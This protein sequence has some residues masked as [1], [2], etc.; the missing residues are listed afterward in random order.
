[1][2]LKD[3]PG[4]A[5][6]MLAALALP[7]LAAPD[8]AAQTIPDSASLSVDYL[9]YR[10]KQPGLDRVGV[11]SPSVHL[12]LPLAGQW[13]LEAGAVSDHVSGATPRYHTAVSGASRMD[14]K[15]NAADL[16]VTRYLGKASVSAGAAHSSE[17]D[18]RSTALSLGGTLSTEDRNTTGGLA[19][20]VSNDTI[21]PVNLLVVG[22]RRHTFEW[23]ASVEQVLGQRDIVKLDFSRSDGHGYYADPYKYADKRPRL[24]KLNS[25]LLRWNHALD[26]GGALRT[27]YRYY[28]DSFGIRS[29]TLGG[30]YER[31]LGGG[32]ALTPALRLYTQSS[33][34]FY[35]DPV[36]DPRFG[37]PFPP[38]YT[39][40][41]TAQLS[42]DQRLSAF[43]AATLGLKLARDVGAG[44]SVHLK[45]ER[46]RQSPNWRWFGDGSPGLA[47]LDAQS[48]QLGMT[49]QW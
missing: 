48:W 43:G 19:I 20:G 18:Y 45:A 49:K 35:F 2:Q 36:Y 44:W 24:R 34:D 32:W 8:A 10:D 46:Y 37:A 11:R 40:G 6:L 14:D 4:G 9:H 7:G 38:G 23:M 27:S 47:R 21:S 22:E 3:S 26:G 5:A 39:F 41:S 12:S 31:A 25:L 15:R 29:H 17:N 13:L 30:E 1:M 16:R 28:T 42:A 33:A